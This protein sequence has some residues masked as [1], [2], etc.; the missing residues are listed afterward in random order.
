MVTLSPRLAELG[1]ILG[2]SFLG[3]DLVATGEVLLAQAS[4]KVTK[5][6]IFVERHR[7]SQRP[8][9]EGILE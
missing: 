5:A 1:E 2:A 8:L 6:P 3:G 9:Q 4:A 7:R